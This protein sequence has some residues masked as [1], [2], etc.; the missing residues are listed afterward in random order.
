MLPPIYY[1]IPKDCFVYSF[2]KI[3]YKK[4]NSLVNLCHN[5]TKTIFSVQLSW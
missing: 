2:A 4:T 5:F 1:Y 3:E